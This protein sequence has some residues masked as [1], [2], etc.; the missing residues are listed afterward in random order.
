MSIDEMQT[1]IEAIARMCGRS[2]SVAMTLHIVDS[3]GAP[4]ENG[5]F[6]ASDAR[7]VTA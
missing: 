6:F 2:M 4:V 5:L 3:E 1:P 7:E